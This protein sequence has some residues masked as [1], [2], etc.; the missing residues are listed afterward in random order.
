MSVDIDF[1]WHNELDNATKYAEIAAIRKRLGDM[2][3]GARAFFAS[4][5]NTQMSV[6]WCIMETFKIPVPYNKCDNLDY[7]AS[8]LWEKG[9]R[10]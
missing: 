9:A 3:L 4:P 10:A 1:N 7:M 8:W 2:E 6:S 5:V